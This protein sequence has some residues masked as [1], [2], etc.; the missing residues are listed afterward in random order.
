MTEHAIDA[1]VRVDVQRDNYLTEINGCVAADVSAP[2]WGQEHAEG[3]QAEDEAEGA[4][5][6]LKVVG[7]LSFAVFLGGI[8]LAVQYDGNDRR[9]QTRPVAESTRFSTM[10]TRFT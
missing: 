4:V 10:A 2:G 9:T 8:V 6:R 3:G 1:V 5:V 7:W